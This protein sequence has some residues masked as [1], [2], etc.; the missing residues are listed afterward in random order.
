MLRL[1]ANL[2]ISLLALAACFSPNLVFAQDTPP[3]AE[4]WILIPKAGHAQELSDAIKEHMDFRSGHGDPWR[5]DSYTPLLGDDL[6]RF[7]VRSCCHNWADVDS[8]REWN[9]NNPAVGTHFGEHVAPHVEK[10]QHYFEEIDWAN[11]HWN[12]EGGP[13][14]YF[15][16]TEFT[17]KAGESADF[18]AAREKMSQIAINQGWADNKRSWLWATTIGGEPLISVI[19]PHVNFASMASTGEGF[20]DFLASQLGS[21]EAAAE[22]MKK[23]SA[24]TWG[25][26]YQVW[27]HREE[28]SMKSGN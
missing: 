12:N 13:Y 1:K 14:K 22:L 16:V 21:A 11:S 15:A 7:A 5:W 23:F 24:A 3:L 8:Y 26:D 25:S 28:L 19:V 10:Y 18:N 17:V 9:N 20:T 6:D 4:M 27:V 2:F